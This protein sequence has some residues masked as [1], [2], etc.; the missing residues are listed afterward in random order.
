MRYGAVEEELDDMQEV[1]GSDPCM[2]GEITNFC[3]ELWWIFVRSPLTLAVNLHNFTAFTA[4]HRK[5]TYEICGKKTN[6]SLLILHIFAFFLDPGI[7]RPS[8]G[9]NNMHPLSWRGGGGAQTEKIPQLLY[10]L[11]KYIFLQPSGRMCHVDSSRKF[12]SR[13]SLLYPMSCLW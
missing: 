12:L 3:G 10:L 13:A 6:F 11:H 8:G 7:A 1:R 5:I 4:F 9:A 2:G